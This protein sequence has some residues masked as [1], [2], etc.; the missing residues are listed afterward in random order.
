M[1][2]CP[3]TNSSFPVPVSPKSKLWNPS[4]R[5][6]ELRGVPCVFF[7]FS[8]QV[9][10]ILQSFDFLTQI[11]H[12]LP[13]AIESFVQLENDHSRCGRS[14]CSKSSCALRTGKETL[15]LEKSFHQFEWRPGYPESTD[16]VLLPAG[17]PNHAQVESVCG[18]Y[19][20]TEIS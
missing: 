12:S 5:P 17:S 20:K 10:E 3:R 11:F 19:Q 7:A 13:T 8:N 6:D 16:I 1:N 4:E 14:E 15:P 2:D 9:T 18:N